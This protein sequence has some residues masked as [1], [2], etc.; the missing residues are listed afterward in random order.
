MPEA[1]NLLLAAGKQHKGTHARIGAL[2]QNCV[3]LALSAEQKQIVF[4]MLAAGK[5][6]TQAAEAVGCSRATVQRLKKNVQ[7]D[8]LLQT[9]QTIAAEKRINEDSNTVLLTLA[10]MKEREPQMQEALWSM[11]SGLSGLFGAA[12]KQ[13][14]PIDISPR[15]LPAIARAAAELAAAYANFSDR[16]N[17]LEAI[18]EGF[19][20]IEA[21]KRGINGTK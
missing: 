18:V 17:G 11:F 8:S 9:A 13:T 7:N 16:I 21:A 15:Q 5:T 6:A 14:D 10:S 4:D 3:I 19:E 12:L 1:L 2:L 20:Q